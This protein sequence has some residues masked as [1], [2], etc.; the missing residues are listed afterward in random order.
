[1]TKVF[2]TTGKVLGQALL[3]SIMGLPTFAQ[4]NMLKTLATLGIPDPDPKAWYDLQIALDFYDKV[5]EDFGPNTLFDLG[6]AVPEKAV[7]PS[8]VDSIDSGMNLIDTA[9][10]MNHK[11]GDIGFYKLISHDVE[12]KKI[13]MHCYN[14]YPCNFDRGLLTAMARKFK[15]GVRVIVDETKPNK[16]KGDNESWYIIT[17]R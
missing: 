10:N 4:N 5:T 7:F 11:E 9:Y 16:A 12:N 6:K 3:T 2:D 17:Y 14:P 8:G 1:M 15:T 13:I